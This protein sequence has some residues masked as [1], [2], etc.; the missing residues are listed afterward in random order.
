MKYQ[1]EEQAKQQASVMVTC[2]MLRCSDK[3]PQCVRED[4]HLKIVQYIERDKIS[5]EPVSNK[6]GYTFH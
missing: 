2:L 6:H 4:I 3:Y 1:E 5:S